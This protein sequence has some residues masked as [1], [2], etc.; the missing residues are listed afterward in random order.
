MATY[1]LMLRGGEDSAADLSPEEIQ[2]LIQPYI[3]WSARLRAEGRHRGG[4]ELKMSGPV[5]RLRGGEFVVDGPYTETKESI[6]GYF[7]I[8]A[9]DEAE[10]VE[11]AKGCPIF[12]HGGFV[13]VREVIEH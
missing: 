4:E 1:M 8:S 7:L 11:V 5:V 3:D 10:A 2:A 12:R 9:A 13:E 6:G